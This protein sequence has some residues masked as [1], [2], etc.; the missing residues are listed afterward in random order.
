[1]SVIYLSFLFGK[2][3]IVNTDT[4]GDF[5]I[6]PHYNTKLLR[7]LGNKKKNTHVHPGGK[8]SDTE[9]GY[10]TPQAA[11]CAYLQH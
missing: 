1:M 8:H 6:G 11:I 10:S 7:G 2:S 5:V 4:Y 3:A 9:L